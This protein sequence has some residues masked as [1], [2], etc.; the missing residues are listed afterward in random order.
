MAFY[1]DP[2]RLLK[3]IRHSFVTGDESQLCE[4]VLLNNDFPLPKGP[5]DSDDDQVID[6]EHVTAVQAES[7]DLFVGTGP[8]RPRTYT[9]IRLEKMRKEK[10]STAKIRHVQ[11]CASERTSSETD[12]EDMFAKKPVPPVRSSKRLNKHLFFLLD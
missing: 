3:Q 9:A 1:D 2:R 8:H 6:D 11:W 12:L 5:Y 7:P 4:H 10:D